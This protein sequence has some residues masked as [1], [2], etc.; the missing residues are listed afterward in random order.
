LPNQCKFPV[1]S[2]Q[3]TPKLDNSGD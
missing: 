3:H 1:E 2:T